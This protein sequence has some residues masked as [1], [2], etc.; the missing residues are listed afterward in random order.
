MT[1]GNVTTARDLGLAVCRVCHQIND[2]PGTKCSQ[3]GAMVHMRIPNSLQK[4]WAFWLAGV[5]CYIPGNLFPIMITETLGNAE[6]STIIGGVVTLIHHHSYTVAAVVFI[7]SVFVPVVKFILIASI[8]LAI[9]L[10]L[11][12]DPHHQHTAHGV[13][14]YIGRWSM[15]DVFVVAALAALIQLGGVIS[16]KPGPGIA[17]FALSVALTM[18]SA[19]ALDP[20][21]IWENDQGNTP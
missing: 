21:L 13:I 4:V 9:Q 12:I 15:V 14:E 6:A 11:P 7:A 19:Q 8:A 20:R 16:I 2:A 18:L 5:I 1:T 3:C 10:K 17:F